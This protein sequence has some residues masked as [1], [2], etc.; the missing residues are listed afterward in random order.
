VKEILCKSI[1]I[2]VKYS[3]KVIAFL[4]ETR[5]LQTGEIYTDLK[6]IIGESDKRPIVSVL[7]Y[8]S[9]PFVL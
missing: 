3:T 8:V 2:Q 7:C 5:K 9:A 6:E 1:N 4:G